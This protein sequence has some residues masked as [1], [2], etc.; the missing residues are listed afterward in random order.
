M[1][2]GNFHC[3]LSVHK[4]AAEEIRNWRS[5]TYCSQVQSLDFE[6]ENSLSDVIAILRIQERGKISSCFIVNVVEQKS[7]VLDQEESHF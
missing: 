5:F 7:Q 3:E 1:N 6:G 2:S 4:F